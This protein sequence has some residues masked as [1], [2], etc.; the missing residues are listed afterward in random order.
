VVKTQVQPGESAVVY[1]AGPMGLFWLCLLRRSG[2]GT[3]ISVEPREKRAEAARKVGAD[4]VIDP[5]KVDPAAE[6]KRLTDGRGADVV[7]ELVGRPEAVELAIKSAAY[8]GRV[9]IMSTCKPDTIVGF[10]PF[11][12]MRS[13]RKIMGSYISNGNFQLAIDALSKGFIPTEVFITHRLP[14][15]EIHRAFELNRKGESIKTLILPGEH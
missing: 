5:T 10:S 6:I 11:E 3:L 12:L 13:E 9:V 14:I 2:A 7:A 8:G 4:A 15:S 1:G